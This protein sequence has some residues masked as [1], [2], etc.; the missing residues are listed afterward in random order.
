MALCKT[1]I[2]CG[3]VEGLPTATEGVSVF[4]GVPFAAPP[5]GHLRWHEPVEHEP[6][7]GVYKCDHFGPACLQQI[8]PWQKEMSPDDE[9]VVYSE[10][11]L[12]LNIWTPATTPGEK[13][14]VMMWI[15]GGGAQGGFPQMKT[16]DGEFLARRGVV[17]VTINYRVNVFGFFGHPELIKESGHESC[18][19][20]GIL[21][22]A[23][24]LRWIHENIEAFGGNPENVT[25]FG[26]SC[27][28]RSTIAMACSPLTEGLIHRAIVHSAAGLSLAG[29]KLTRDDI[30]KNGEILMERMGVKTLQEMRDMDA[31]KLL[32]EYLRIT[33][34]YLNSDIRFNI[35]SDGYVMPWDSADS[36]MGNHY[37]VRSFMLGRTANEGG[38]MAVEEGDRI[39]RENLK[40]LGPEIMMDR[41]LSYI[42]DLYDPQTDEEARQ[43]YIDV[44]TLVMKAAQDDWA[45]LMLERGQDAPYT[46]CFSRPAPGD[47]SGAYH[48]TEL[49]YVFGTLQKDWRP[50]TQEDYALSETAADYWTN[51]A[52]TGNPN[53]EGL[54]QWT[55]YTQ[56]SPLAMKLDIDECCMTDNE[57]VY[58]K[59]LK[60]ILLEKA[61]G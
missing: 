41:S 14:P 22:Q 9:E 2:R 27:G 48:G 31:Q 24:A 10:D 8:G 59:K 38:L 16:F 52:R 26:Q 53:G 4:K 25:V 34:D 37:H 17:L 30:A 44:L 12:Y 11:C 45:D 36:I 40:T 29:G 60:T 56:E 6:W 55:P 1:R 61:K 42:L 49:W 39:T 21:D 54:A 47:R 58:V 23:F 7:E 18:G 20:Y 13:L 28:G 57:D 32:D 43:A 50:Y 51:F 33:G 15:F 35:C 46:C 5:V 3:E 19:N